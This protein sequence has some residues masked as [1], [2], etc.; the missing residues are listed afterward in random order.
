MRSVEKS[1]VFCAHTVCAPRGFGSFPVGRQQV[2][3]LVG[4]SV[5]QAAHTWA[6]ALLPTLD[7]SSKSEGYHE[8]C[9]GHRLCLCA[10]VIASPYPRIF[11]SPLMRV[12]G[13]ATV[14]IHRRCAERQVGTPDNQRCGLM[15]ETV[16]VGEG[17]GGSLAK[18]R[19][20]FGS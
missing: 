3:R 5:C 17:S 10:Y 12:P 7:L 19:V 15:G 4:L 2:A 11:A 9:V 20:V 13:P 16:A 8:S 6:G 18:V 1:K 14:F